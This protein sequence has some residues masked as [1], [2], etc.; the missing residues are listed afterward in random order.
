MYKTKM[1]IVSKR[2][3]ILDKQ[4]LLPVYADKDGQTQVTE[5]RSGLGMSD[6]W[7]QETHKLARLGRLVMIYKT[8]SEVRGLRRVVK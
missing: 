5:A 3:I 2:S 4:P 8:N 7:W 1:A 6:A